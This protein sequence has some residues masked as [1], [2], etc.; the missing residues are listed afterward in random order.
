MT[1]VN[2]DRLVRIVEGLSDNSV[3]AF[4]Q[5]VA[6]WKVKDRR[7]ARLL[8]L[9]TKESCTLPRSHANSDKILSRY[10]LVRR[11]DMYKSRV[12]MGPNYRAD[13]WALLEQNPDLKAA[14]LARLAY[15]SFATAWG[16]IRDKQ[17]LT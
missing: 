15:A 17:Q 1:Y 8:K 4:W 11:H 9:K 2:A 14:E 16:V 12:I 6:R 10:D 13:M 5:S 7:L 3:K